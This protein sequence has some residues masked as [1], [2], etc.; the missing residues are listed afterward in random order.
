[1]LIPISFNTM[2]YILAKKNAYVDLSK[3]KTVNFV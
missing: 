3:K 2:F 1:M